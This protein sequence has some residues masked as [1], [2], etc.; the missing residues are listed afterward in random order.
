[1]SDGGAGRLRSVGVNLAVVLGMNALALVIA[2]IVTAVFRDQGER[3][4]A[5]VGCALAYGWATWRASGR[6]AEDRGW[7][8]LR[9]HLVFAGGHFITLTLVLEVI[10]TTL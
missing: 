9:R 6:L 8:P 5:L 4:V 1:V 3:G 2:L 10:A 7:P